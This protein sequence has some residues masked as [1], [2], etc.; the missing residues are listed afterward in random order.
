MNSRR[1]PSLAAKLKAKRLLPDRAPPPTKVSEGGV[2]M[3]TPNC[4]AGLSFAVGTGIAVPSFKA[5]YVSQP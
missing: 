1:V 2:F 3:L 5:K 4:R